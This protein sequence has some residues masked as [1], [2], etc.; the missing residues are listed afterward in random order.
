MNDSQ[1]LSSI[2][3]Q[4]PLIQ[5]WLRLALADSPSKL[6]GNITGKTFG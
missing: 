6:I 2:S 3:S 1:L 4:L 5:V